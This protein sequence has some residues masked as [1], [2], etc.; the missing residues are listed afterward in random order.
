MRL[1]ELPK[2]VLYFVFG[3]VGYG[4]MTLM[5][6]DCRWVC[7]VTIIVFAPSPPHLY[8]SR[9]CVVKYDQF[10]CSIAYMNDADRGC[11]VIINTWSY[12]Y[13]LEPPRGC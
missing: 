13:L 1:H 4:R 3:T 9:L 2:A 7:N 11:G 8:M 5:I 10:V 12:C 6:D